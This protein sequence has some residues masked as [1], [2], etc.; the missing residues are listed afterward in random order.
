MFELMWPWMLL[1]LPLPLF[2]WWFVPEEQNDQ[3][4]AIK[5]PSL[6]DFNSA[7]GGTYYAK[8]NY[9]RFL[10]TLI[11]WILLVFAGARPQWLGE[12]DPTSINGRNMMLAVDVSISM[13]RKD[14]VVGNL[15]SSR[16]RAAKAV[17]GDFVKRRKGDRVGLIVFGSYAHLYVPLTFDTVTLK[18]M[19]DE[20]FAG[21]AGSQT[22]VGDAI[23]L[24]VKLLKNH[25]AGNKVLVLMTDGK[26][27]IGSL[28]P[29]A[30][31]KIAKKVGLKIY[32]I[33]IGP[34]AVVYD[35]RGF[36]RRRRANSSDLDE[37]SLKQIAKITGGK[38]FHASNTQKLSSIYSY[39]DQLEP[40][41]GDENSLRPRVELYYWLI[42]V[43]FI[44]VFSSVSFR[45][46]AA[47]KFNVRGQH[48]R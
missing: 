7:V 19:L 27:N 44:L 43:C 4:S 3:H 10:L 36:Y 8:L 29:V 23:G 21:I 38:Y 17:V 46:L 32:T 15:H 26:H 40:V 48:D 13:N 16:L 45:L 1:F 25:K 33:G 12:V 14:F 39:L 20:T 18:T 42:S 2:V 41:K 22:T 37:A 11:V 24:A 9:K 31:A 34:E 30:A 35:S 47:M 5:I 6:V 28:D